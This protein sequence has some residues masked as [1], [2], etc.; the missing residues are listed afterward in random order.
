MEVER[1]IASFTLNICI[2]YYKI[3]K[4]NKLVHQL[5]FLSEW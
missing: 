4:Q 2:L 3:G 1:E 5:K